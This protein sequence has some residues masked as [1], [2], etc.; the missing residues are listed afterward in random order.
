L[1]KKILNKSEADIRPSCEEPI[2]GDIQQPGNVETLIQ[3]ITQRSEQPATSAKKV[4]NGF[5]PVQAV[6]AYDEAMAV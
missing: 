2:C 5:V 1:R 6:K 3:N 4:R